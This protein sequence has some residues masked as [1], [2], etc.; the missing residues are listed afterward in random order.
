[1]KAPCAAVG[2]LLPGNAPGETQDLPFTIK[3]AE[4]RGVVSE[5]ML[6][7]AKELGLSDDHSGLMS[8]PADAAVGRSTSVAVGK[9]IGRRIF[10]ELITDGR[11]YSATSAEFRITRWLV[12]LGTISTIGDE[13]INLKASK[14]Y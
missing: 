6:C 3:R 2:A 4:V 9:Y 10:V 1:M 7:S 8:L 5:G 11:G 13:S 14:D 12:L